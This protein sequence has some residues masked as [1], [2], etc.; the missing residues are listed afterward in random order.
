MTIGYII[1]SLFAL[2]IV[3]FGLWPYLTIFNLD[4]VLQ[5]TDNT[6]IEKFTP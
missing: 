1:R 2:L 5:Q 6:A 4:G 3:A